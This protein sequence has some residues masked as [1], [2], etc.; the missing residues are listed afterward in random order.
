MMPLRPE[1]YARALPLLE[2]PFFN[3][4]FARAVLE[5]RV[6][7]AVHADHPVRPRVAHILHPCGMSLLCGAP[8]PAGAMDTITGYLLDRLGRRSAVEML[9]AHPGAWHDRLGRSLGPRLQQGPRG[10]GSP[11]GASL[12]PPAVDRVVQFG[13]VNFRFDPGAFEA[14]APRPLPEGLSV[15]RAGAEA[16]APWEGAVLPRSFWDSPGDFARDGAAF[17]VRDG[18]RL[19]AVAFSAWIVGGALEIGIETAAGA[20]RAGLAT[21]ACSALIRHC[22]ERRLL[23]VWSAH[24]HNLGSHALAEK[25]GFRRTYEVPY[26]ALAARARDAAPIPQG[27]SYWEQLGEPAATGASC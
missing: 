10:P 3:V 24:S 9:Q 25:L 1:A 21:H 16:F 14:L 4:L 18:A 17:A 26:Y 20:R 13:R 2:E 11:E 7:G 8:P 15:A 19:L 6:R 27:P 5:R 12:R 22:L 23:P